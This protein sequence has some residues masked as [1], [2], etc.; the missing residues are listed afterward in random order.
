MSENK[1]GNHRAQYRTAIM[2]A[3]GVAGA[4]IAGY[5][6]DFST[7]AET[8]RILVTAGICGILGA[9]ITK[10]VTVMG[11]YLRHPVRDLPAAMGLYA[12]TLGNPATPEEIQR[13]RELYKQNKDIYLEPAYLLATGELDLLEGKIESAFDKYED[14]IAQMPTYFDTGLFHRFSMWLTEKR[15]RRAQKGLE[16]YK[17]NMNAAIMWQYSGFAKR[18]Q[19]LWLEAVSQNKDDIDLNI[20]YGRALEAMGEDALAAEQWKHVLHIVRDQAAKG[21]NI[22]LEQIEGTD[23]YR[24]KESDVLENVFVLKSC[25]DRQALEDELRLTMDVNAA[26]TP[27]LKEHGLDSQYAIGRSLRVTSN[28]THSLVS[29]Y[30]KGTILLDYLKETKDTTKLEQTARFLAIIH[31]VMHA[32][33]GP[34]R[35]EPQHFMR[36]MGMLKARLNEEGRAHDTRDLFR[37]LEESYT[38]PLKHTASSQYVFN[39]D[40]H[41]KNWSV[42]PDGRI[43]AIDLQP[44]AAA[45]PEDELSKLI[46]TGRCLP[47]TPA[48][49]LQR[50][51]IIESYRKQMEEMGVVKMPQLSELVFRKLNADLIRAASFFCFSY[52]NDK[53]RRLRTEYTQNAIHSA[54]RLQDEYIDIFD[55]ED[56]KQYASFQKGLEGL[57]RLDEV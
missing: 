9:G 32:Y 44:R 17:A 31:S 13:H 1:S 35:D 5:P 51:G 21:K 18:A 39:R 6:F 14:V 28:A 11:N 48:A 10:G 49:D 27:W 41:G 4:A 3:G 26:V 42:S 24:L 37:L 19:K 46:E 23:V 50:D 52:C 22:S 34:Q 56:I 57:L 43:T 36:R 15:N 20:L 2:I 38:L 25:D 40:A 47:N 29:L 45:H 53:G 55:P 7:T 12:R 8:Q 30:E 16:S 33:A 54:H